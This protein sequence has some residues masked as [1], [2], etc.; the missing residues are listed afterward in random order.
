[1]GDER[2]LNTSTA[3]TLVRRGIPAVLIMQYKITDRA[4]IEFSSAFYEA[5]VDSLPVDAAVAE[6]R[7]AISLAVM[8]T[9]EWGTPVLYMRSPNGV[10]FNILKK[11]KEESI[12]SGSMPAD[13][14]TVKQQIS[15]IPPKI[16]KATMESPVNTEART[17]QTIKKQIEPYE[18]IKKNWKI[19]LLVMVIV[20]LTFLFRGLWIAPN[21]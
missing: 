19:I 7:K 8:N 13:S 15:P 1:M 11:S 5:L 2:D 17:S 21:Q 6:A 12:F 4:A 16:I 3:S 18:W 14:I 20:I 10:L 9:V